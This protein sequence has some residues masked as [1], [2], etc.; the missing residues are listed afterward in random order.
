MKKSFDTVPASSVVSKHRPD[1]EMISVKAENT[2]LRAKIQKMRQ[3]IGEQKELLSDV[4]AHV[5]KLP[6]IAPRKLD[7]VE[8]VVSSP[9]IANVH[10]TDW[11]IGM[12]ADPAEI[13]DFNAFDFGIAK[14]RVA[15][16]GQSI[17]NWVTMHRGAYTVDEIVLHCTG[18]FV[19]G[20]IHQELLVTNEFPT[21]VQA[22]KAGGLLSDFVA[23]LA[24]HFPKI[25]VEFVTLDNHG[26]LTKKP[27][28]SQGGFNNW[29]YV[30][31]HVAAERLAKFSQVQFNIYPRASQVVEVNGLRYLLMHGNGIMGTWG[32]PWYGIERRKQ[33][34]SM[35]RMNMEVGK[36]FDK[37]VLGH[38]HSALNHEHWQIGGSLS[39]TDAND[40]TEGRHSRPHQTVWMVHPKHGEFDWLRFYL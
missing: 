2:E 28:K 1:P 40:H 14:D 30:V 25:R 7:T 9:C 19:S 12:K 16:L 35:A 3:D 36:H 20:D 27:Q 8:R 5:K 17:V 15:Q 18:D 23:M 38:F 39:G 37:I 29:S 26:R 22:V 33:R 34:E 6:A 11:H 24:P 4:L 32:I 31:G 13:E 10:C 21:P